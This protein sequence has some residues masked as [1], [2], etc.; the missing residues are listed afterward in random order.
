MTTPL[1]LRFAAALERLNTIPMPLRKHANNVTRLI[2]DDGE[3]PSDIAAEDAH[4]EIL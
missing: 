2:D 3:Q 4:V 1:S